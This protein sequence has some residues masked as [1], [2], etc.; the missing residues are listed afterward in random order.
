MT[1]AIS[2]GGGVN[3]VAM[4]ILLVN[5]G[6]RGPIAFAETGCEWP[7]TYSYI[8]MFD[9]TWL[10][11]RG[12][13]VT[14]IGAE[15]RTAGYSRA[16]LIDYCESIVATPGHRNRWCT[17]DWKVR[18]IGR[19]REANSVDSLYIGIAADESQRK[20]NGMDCPLCDR[21]ITRDGCKQI[22]VNG[23]LPVPP[24]SGCYMCF[25]QHPDQWRRLWELH[26]DLF[27]RV[28]RLDDALWEKG[29]YTILR[30]SRKQPIRLR[31]M[32]RGFARQEVLFSLETSNEL[33]WACMV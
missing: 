22:I 18:P 11:P 12:L 32:E 27:E 31:S 20:R 13:S 3:S 7:E 29:R 26:P 19:W 23:G 30:D 4:T 16:P 21:L 10:Q 14:R 24:K 2:F 9:R 17:L 33:C 5:E 1:E 28:A 6:W 15:W 8:E 25:F